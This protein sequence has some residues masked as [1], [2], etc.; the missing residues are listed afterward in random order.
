MSFNTN[1]SRVL[2]PESP[3]PFP[4]RRATP[5]ES[6]ALFGLW[7]SFLVTS[8]W[9]EPPCPA[10]LLLSPMA[11]S[12]SPAWPDTARTL[13]C[14]DRPACA[15][16]T[17]GRGRGKSTWRAGGWRVGISRSRRPQNA[18]EN[19][20]QNL[21]TPTEAMCILTG[22]WSGFISLQGCSH[23]QHH[24]VP[25]SHG[26]MESYTEKVGDST[27]YLEACS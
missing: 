12:V 21:Q 13:A 1:G 5:L 22:R 7:L 11:E 8:V 25:S 17:W 14:C 18:R 24:P 15:G 20:K 23:F 2:D 27:V 9:M 4:P 19:R 10:E 26:H 16:L 3:P 6:V